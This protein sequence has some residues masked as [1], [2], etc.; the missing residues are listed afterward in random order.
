[1][2]H[3]KYK[4]NKLNAKKYILIIVITI[5]IF[6]F[7]ELIAARFYYYYYKDSLQSS[8]V[9]FELIQKIIHKL[10][11]KRYEKLNNFI[12]F[13][14]TH[15][16]SY[17]SYTFNPQLHSNG[18]VYHLA[19]PINSTIVLFNEMGKR[20]TYESDELGFRNPKNQKNIDCD[21]IFIGDSYTEG[22]CVDDNDTIAGQF[23]QNGFKVMNFGR[24]GT[25]PIF[26]LA[27]LKEYGNYV[28]T[29]NIIWFVFGGNDYLNLREEKTTIL[30]RYLYEEKFTQNLLDNRYKNSTILKGFLDRELG[31]SKARMKHK[32]PL[33][34]HTKYGETLDEYEIIF[35]EKNLFMMVAEKILMESKK[36]NSNLIVVHIDHAF[37]NNIIKDSTIQVLRHFTS[38]NN[39]KFIEIERQELINNHNKYYDAKVGH[40]SANGYRSVAKHLLN[41]LNH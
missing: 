37:Y 12:K 39:L 7:L 19:N 34:Y 10:Q 38:K 25:G 31:L 9:S 20:I 21:F 29:N 11:D 2:S 3:L 30:Q 40:F 24:G 32:I 16:N 33:N 6:S 27:T 4:Y 17:M 8:L 14:E 35:K 1:M 36:L 15:Y 41:Q 26:Q 28:N 13:N 5:T 22:F 23:R 18:S